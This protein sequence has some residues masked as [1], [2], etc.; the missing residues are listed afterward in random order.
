[1]LDKAIDLFYFFILLGKAFQNLSVSSPAP[2]TIVSPEGFMAR[3]RTRL[4]WPVS[5]VVF[6][7]EGYF[8]M[9]ISLFEYPWVLTIS[10]VFLENMRLQTCEPVSMLSSIDPSSVF[11]NLI[12]LSAEPPPEAKTPWLWGLQ[13]MPLTAAVWDVN[14]QIGV[15]L[16]A[17]QMNNLLSLPPEA[18]RLWSNDHFSPQT[19]CV[20]P[21]YFETILLYRYLT[22]RMRMLLSLE[23][24]ARIPSPQATELTLALCPPYSLTLQLLVTSQSYI[25]PL[26]VPMAIWEPWL[27]QLRLEMES[28]TRSQNLST[29]LL[30]AFQK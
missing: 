27:F 24:L 22:S 2:V 17:L 25:V 5:V 9:M 12:V 11:Q 16:F 3:K 13:A 28:G 1:M 29:L 20:W 10:L 8:H 18:S 4:E 14:L 26:L 30:L 7:S 19:S 6:W 15:V 21:S 23:P